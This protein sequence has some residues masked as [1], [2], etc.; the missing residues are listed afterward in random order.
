MDRTVVWRGDTPVFPEESAADALAAFGSAPGA[1]SAVLPGW[2]SALV[3][4]DCGD[5]GYTGLRVEWT[6]AD[7]PGKIVHPGL[8]GWA[9][10]VDPTTADASEYL[11]EWG[12]TAVL[13]VEG[14][15]L[16]DAVVSGSASDQDWRQVLDC[17]AHGFAAACAG[18]SVEGYPGWW[19][20]LLVDRVSAAGWRGGWAGLGEYAAERASLTASAARS[21]AAADSFLAVVVAGNRSCP[22]EVLEYLAC[23]SRPAVVSAVARNPAATDRCR[24]YAVMS[25]GA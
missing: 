25:E 5:Y 24:A 17:G 22:T 14:V 1:V 21:L 13:S 15:R 11:A 8:D 3:D 19:L 6:H 7:R 12:G 2:R 4:G 9:D 23:D 20:D 18:V 16:W 10:I